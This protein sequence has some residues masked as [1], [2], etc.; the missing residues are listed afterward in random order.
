MFI[1]TEIIHESGKGSA[2]SFFIDFRLPTF[3]YLWLRRFQNVYILKLRN[4]GNSSVQKL[5][6]FSMLQNLGSPKF[7]TKCYFRMIFFV[8]NQTLSVTTEWTSSI[9]VSFKNCTLVREDL[10]KETFLLIFLSKSCWSQKSERS[11]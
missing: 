6:F 7:E 8:F 5:S 11:N 1:K 3:P 9:N 2:F 10:S 4:V